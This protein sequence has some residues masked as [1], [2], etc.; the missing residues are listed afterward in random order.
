[1]LDRRIPAVI[2]GA[3]L[4]IGLTAA[5][6]SGQ[7]ERDHS[8]ERL[9]AVATSEADRVQ[10]ALE[11]LAGLGRA[12][13]VA[14]DRAGTVDERTYAA[15]VEQLELS[16]R[17]PAVVGVALVDRVERDALPGWLEGQQRQAP[18][19]RLGA[20]A[21]GEVLW[22]VRHAYPEVVRSR[23]LGVDLGA[24]P[25]VADAVDAAIATGR[26]QL[27]S[28]TELLSQADDLPG[29]ILA[30]PFIDRDGRTQGVFG[31]GLSQ[32]TFIEAIAPDADRVHVTI[33]NPDSTRFPTVLEEGDPPVG[34]AV[35]TR[36]IGLS[37]TDWVIEVRPTA[38]FV[39]PWA[40]LAPWLLGVSTLLVAGMT[41]VAVGALGSRERRASELAEHRTR[42]LQ[43]AVADLAA[44]N[45][46][47]READEMKDRFLA[48]VSHELRTPLTVIAGFAETLGRL[49]A[50]DETSR[51]AL[52]GPLR[53]NVRRLDALVGD[54]L[55][56]ASL[57]AG[58]LVAKPEPI[59]LREAVQ[60]LAVDLGLSDEGVLDNRVPEDLRLTV[61]PHHLDHILVNLL[62]NAD[63]H[64]APP[65]TVGA[66]DEDGSVRLWVRDHGPGLGDDDPR[67]LLRRFER[68]SNV[69][70]ANGTGLGLAIVAELATLH[71]GQVRLANADPGA[72][73]E[74]TLPR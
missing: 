46:Q 2:A 12:M 5:V 28:A 49:P 18:G 52:L 9:E 31:I 68:G 27:S 55:L 67:R 32:A 16:E 41:W 72:R 11:A 42:E 29:A 48:S 30:V 23:L 58:G 34:D 21:A 44:A 59:A 22:P 47:L 57:D 37:T 40:Q 38:A 65:L 73:I 54:L 51:E 24:L 17:F 10:D 6:W 43:D 39:A 13:G 45:A 4:A 20:D 53:R 71:G 50:D 56:L 3:I 26:S 7:A 8:R 14:L 1:V 35:E 63:K 70:H 25:A 66:E 61:D 60:R 15:V 64:G 69:D 36:R 19:F 62:A 33:T 74:V